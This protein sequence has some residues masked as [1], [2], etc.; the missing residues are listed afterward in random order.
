[1]CLPESVGAIRLPRLAQVRVV[2]YLTVHTDD[3]AVLVPIHS[4]DVKR[5]GPF[6]IRNRR[7]SRSRRRLTIVGGGSFHFAELSQLLHDSW[8]GIV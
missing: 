5:A 8:I 3:D 1:V 2:Q 4:P 6:W 7:D